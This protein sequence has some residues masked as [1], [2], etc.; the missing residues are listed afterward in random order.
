MVR[1]LKEERPAG[2]QE[3]AAWDLMK[4]A[5]DILDI[6]GMSSEESEDENEM[7]LQVNRVK[8]LPWRWD[9]TALLQQVD[10]LRLQEQDAFAKQGSKPGPRSRSAS[11][12]V[13][14]RK[15]PSGWPISL[16]D[17]D[18]LAQQDSLYV[19]NFLRPTLNT[20]DLS[21]LMIAK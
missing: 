18:W 11:N 14:T 16:Y 19:R 21:V 4:E 9:V 6:A 15:P 3:L 17:P 13:S 12:P 7:T 8:I 1:A 5:V 20:L 2:D 10:N